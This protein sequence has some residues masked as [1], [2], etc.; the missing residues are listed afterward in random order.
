VG[1]PHGLDGSFYVEA[2]DA[3]LLAV[4]AEIAVGGRPAT[5]VRRGGTAARPLVWL[6][7]VGD[8]AGAEALRGEELVAAAEES[9]EPVAGEWDASE[10]I[11]CEVP[12][13]GSVR[14]VVAAPSCDLLEVGDAGV[15]VPFVSDAVRRVDPAAG[16]IDVDLRFM[17]LEEGPEP[18]S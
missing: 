1:R 5:V 16:V 8:R 14:R 11:G 10:L 18:P 7:G 13:I 9:S 6:S 3:E 2:A 15:L 17:G 4:G 12:G